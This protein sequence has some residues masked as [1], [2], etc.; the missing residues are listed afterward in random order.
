MVA[1]RVALAEDIGHE[2]LA[3][4]DSMETPEAEAPEP[5]D[6]LTKMKKGGPPEPGA[7]GVSRAVPARRWY[8]WQTLLADAVPA[9]GLT[10]LAS[11]RNTD[12]KDTV[13]DFCAV[14]YVVGA[15]IVHLAH[16]QGGK[17]A[18]S[19]LIRAAGPLL[20]VGG[21]ANSS[22]SNNGAGIGL[23][24]VG[25]LSIP[26]VIAV[27]SA[28]IA[29]E[30]VTQSDRSSAFRDVGL[31]PLFDRGHGAAGMSLVGRF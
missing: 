25:A 11:Q 13:L 31:A 16:G 23:A 24:V 5:G 17:A 2:P 21:T 3:P 27:D 29:R 12:S 26:A 1:P 30:D 19:L 28:V 14:T 6:D 4:P 18:L 7:D 10:I 20:I 22:S 8:G 15:P 9:F